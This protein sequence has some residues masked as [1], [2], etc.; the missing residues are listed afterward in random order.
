[1]DPGQIGYNRN[2]TDPLVLAF[3]RDPTDFQVEAGVEFYAPL[4]S[5]SS[6]LFTPLVGQGQIPDIPGNPMEGYVGAFS[7]HDWDQDGIPEWDRFVWTPNGYGGLNL[8]PVFR[9]E[10]GVSTRGGN[11]VTTEIFPLPGGTEATVILHPDFRQPGA[12]IFRSTTA[13]ITPPLTNNPLNIT[14]PNGSY[15]QFVTRQTGPN[16][17]ETV[18][19]FYT[20][21][22]SPIGEVIYQSVYAP[23]TSSE[24]RFPPPPYRVP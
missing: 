2:N 6:A 20:Q 1:M 3:Y 22:G 18:G 4:A 8:T 10:W 12:M 9:A 14:Y 11:V 5:G 23:H 17:I 16:T 7:I 13:E 21:S 24:L 19:G 15:I